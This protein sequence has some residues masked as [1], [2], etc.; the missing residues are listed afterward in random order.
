[1]YMRFLALVAAVLL[2]ACPAPS[3]TAERGTDGASPAT[4]QSELQAAE[5]LVRATRAT[6]EAGTARVVL[7]SKSAVPDMYVEVRAR[8]EVDFTRERGAMRMRVRGASM[9]EKVTR[10]GRAAV[11]DA[12]YDGDTWYTRYPAAES[13]SGKRWLR[14]E[15]FGGMAPVLPFAPGTDPRDALRVARVLAPRARVAGRS[16]VAGVAAT[17]FEGRLPLDV[18]FGP[19]DGDEPDRGASDP[20]DDVT[21]EAWVDD[22]GRFVQLRVRLGPSDSAAGGFG[23][24]VRFTDLGDEV[25]IT[26]PT[27]RMVDDIDALDIDDIDAFDVPDH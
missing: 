2:T 16:Q 23:W 27:P 9:R 12:L 21:V 13:A 5:R 3:R 14:S 1:M 18:A 26:L 11:S 10:F 15:S 25:N 19:T 4:G 22:L 8:G 24:T 6:A 20:S 7:R 17:R